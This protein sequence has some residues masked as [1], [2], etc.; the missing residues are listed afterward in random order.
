ML[1]ATH[2]RAHGTETHRWQ[3]EL[4][5]AALGSIDET[6]AGTPGIDLE[7]PGLARSRRHW[8]WQAHLGWEAPRTLPLGPGFAD[9]QR[10]TLAAGPHFQLQRGWRGFDL[11]ADLLAGVI[12]TH[13]GGVAVPHLDAGLEPGFFVGGR[14]F[15][16]PRPIWRGWLSVGLAVWPVREQVGLFSGNASIPTTLATIPQLELL[17]ALGGSWLD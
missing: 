7:L 16:D 3:L 12:V 8:G 4:G 5:G 14:F 13:G 2:A 10:I 6:G 9:W 15:A 17:L 11:E 1:P